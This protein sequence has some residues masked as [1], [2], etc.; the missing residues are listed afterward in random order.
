MHAIWEVDANVFWADYDPG[1]AGWGSIQNVAST[2]NDV[3]TDSISATVDDSNYYTHLLYR[4]D[5][6]GEPLTRYLYY[7]QFDGTT[8]ATSLE[9]DSVS[10]SLQIQYPTI[11]YDETNDDLY[12]FWI[13]KNPG[14]FPPQDKFVYRWGSTS[15]YWTP[16]WESEENIAT[17]TYLMYGASSNF[18]ATPSS[19]VV[20][21]QDT[22]A[23]TND[24]K[25]YQSPGEPPVANHD[26]T[27]GTATL[28]GGSS[29][30]LVENSSTTV[31]ATATVSDAEGHADI[32]T[33]IG[34]ALRSGVSA[35]SCV[36]NDNNCY[37]D[38]SCV[39]SSCSGDSCVATCSWNLWFHADPTDS[40]DY[41]AQNWTACFDV[42]DYQ[43][44]SGTSAALSGVELNTLVALDLSTSSILYLY[45]WDG[46]NLSPGST[47][48]KGDLTET[49]T[50]TDTG[51]AAIYT[52]ISGTH[53]YATTGAFIGVDQQQYTTTSV[54]GYGD[55]DAYTLSPDPT[56]IELDLTKPTSH[57]SNSTDDVYWGLQIPS[58][59]EAAYYSGTTTFTAT[60]TS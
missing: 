10:E 13:L 40:G 26:P 35:T 57:P 53:L 54:M 2:V 45:W 31:S 49:T 11:S 29:I 32:E 18:S 9:L 6:G 37:H 55:G 4:Y 58:T 3:I 34:R 12:A 56:L 39:T 33:I 23:P 21:T 24:I 20:F 28:N 43:D 42:Y 8:W 15:P 30:T 17:S 22:I 50:I 5:T 25:F 27:A 48:N 14:T 51:N 36:Q 52:Y 47:S 60:P 46:E 44:A 59:Q 7:K 41:S 38:Y 16:N 19:F 1:G